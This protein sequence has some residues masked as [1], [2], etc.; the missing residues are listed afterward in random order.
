MFIISLV[1]GIFL[2]YF[3]LYFHEFG[4]AI[5]AIIFRKQ[6]VKIKLGGNNDKKL[7]KI[8]RL[9]IYLNGFYPSYGVVYWNTKSLSKYKRALI[10]LSSPIF[11]LLL[12]LMIWYF[13]EYNPSKYINQNMIKYLFVSSIWQFVITIIPIRYP[14]FWGGY[15]GFNSDGLKAIKYLTE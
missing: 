2:L 4:H 6:E 10:C 12:S 7:I 15:G 11:S 5:F 1:I 14:K 8:G 13:L 3:I 9:L